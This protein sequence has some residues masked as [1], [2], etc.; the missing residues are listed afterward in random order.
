VTDILSYVGV[1][2][3][4]DIALVAM[5][6]YTLMRQ[7]RGTRAAKMLLGLVVLL[8][9]S[10]VA[11]LVPLYT[12]DWLLNGLWAYIVIGLIVVFQPEIRRA[13]A[14]MGQTSLFDALASAE[15]MK[16]IEEVVRATVSLS[17]S[18]C[19]ALIVLERGTMLDD[20]VELGTQ[21]DAKISME[22][23]LALFL[24]NSPI[25]DGSVVIRGNRIVAAGCFLPISLSSDIHRTLGTRHR[26]AL[27]ITE[28]TDC[29]VVV[30]SEETG[31]M[32]VVLD[33]KLERIEDIDALRIRLRE[34]FIRKKV[35]A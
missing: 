24:P 21:L 29:V 15:E 5:V 20:F 22:V 3:L 32:S 1:R 11:R 27:G 14:R 23:L 9:V 16:G 18:R 31:D 30:V 12:L 33:N 10:I 17:R 28:E 13:L 2:D 19:G 4:I 35:K 6:V 25:H 7:V 26:A 8:L 34:L